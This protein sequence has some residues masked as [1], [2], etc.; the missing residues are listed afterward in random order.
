MMSSRE[1]TRLDDDID[2]LLLSH[3]MHSKE[4]IKKERRG[5]SVW[6]HPYTWEW[7]RGVIHHSFLLALKSR[8]LVA[9]KERR[10]KA[11]T[12]GLL[13]RSSKVVPFPVLLRT[14]RCSSAIPSSVFPTFSSVSPLYIFTSAV[15]ERERDWFFFT[16]FI[17]VFSGPL[18]G[19]I[20]SAEQKISLSFPLPL[21][22]SHSLSIGKHT[23]TREEV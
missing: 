15:L 11:K 21:S 16:F 18:F 10:R 17:L 23:N 6:I 13:A 14:A 22:L 3:Q 7:Q 20:L 19:F 8:V 5:W 4:R 12:L 1:R 9:S 2:A